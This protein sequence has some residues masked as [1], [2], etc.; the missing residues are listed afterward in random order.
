[1]RMPHEVDIYRRN[2]VDPPGK[3]PKFDW[4][5]R[6]EDTEVPAFVQPASSKA[7]EIAQ[8]LRNYSISHTVFFED[9]PRLKQQDHILYCGR[10]LQ[11]QAPAVNL[12]EMD[13]YW[14]CDV[15][16]IEWIQNS[17]ENS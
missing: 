6:D 14:R 8:R 1:M 4:T 16:E 5:V 7:I 13:R 17:P 11:V 10:R 15:Q 2:R 9:D 3:S 12:M